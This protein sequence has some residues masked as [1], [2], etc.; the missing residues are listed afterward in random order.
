MCDRAF[1]A[2]GTPFDVVA[3]TKWCGEAASA[4]DANALH[5]MGLMHL[6]GLGG[7]RD[8]DAAQRDCAGAAERG[9]GN[10]PTAF[11]LAAVS[12]E[13][14]SQDPAFQGFG[15]TVDRVTG[16]PLP[17]TLPDPF[18]A[19]RILDQP[20]RTPGGLD[21]TCRKL[22]EW[23]RF[24]APGLVI[25]QPRD[26]V[27][28]K[29]ILSYGRRDF[30]ELDRAATACADAL[31]AIAGNDGLRRDLYD[32]RSSIA[33]LKTR[34]KG[35]QGE[36]QEASAE[37]AQ[38]AR[39]RLQSEHDQ[40]VQTSEVRVIASLATPQEQDCAEEIR[41]G[42]AGS[43]LGE[44]TTLQIRNST[45]TQTSGNY[46]VRGEARVLETAGGQWREIREYAP[47]TC[48]FN[49]RAIATAELSSPSLGYKPTQTTQS[50]ATQ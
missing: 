4:G 13:H 34:Q 36:R 3:V 2:A 5:R 39:D 10:P 25:L 28:G 30:D 40:Q 12:E 11:C 15:S 23:E 46:V 16:R 19:D 1:A 38:I 7:N 42:I 6:A 18:A 49:G 47:Y 22:G 45:R 35:L 31:G 17:A 43:L 33:A 20:H 9:H 50:N 48:T 14:R 27:F 8:L 24:E 41:R 29:P 37:A 32:F 44:Q 21:Y 26:K